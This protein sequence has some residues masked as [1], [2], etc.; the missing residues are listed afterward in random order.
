[1]Y[2]CQKCN[3][4]V[5]PNQKIHK[6]VVETRPRTYTLARPVR[7]RSRG[8]RE[9]EEPLGQ[10][11]GYEIAKELEVCSTCASAVAAEQAPA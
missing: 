4:V 5:G 10:A 1:M 3:I 6:V 7:A 9:E 2:R 11:N 8:R